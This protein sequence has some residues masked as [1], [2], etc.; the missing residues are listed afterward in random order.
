MS[1]Q[2][3]PT[4]SDALDLFLLDARA[5]SLA[6]NTITT[7]RFKLSPFV[8]WCESKEL[9][10][11]GEVTSVHL[12]QFIIA[13][14]QKD[15]SS[16][17][18]YNIA[19]TVKTFFN[20]CVTETLIDKSPFDRVK[21]PRLEKKIH[22]ALAQEEIKQILKACRNQRDRA[23]C[24]V[25]LDSGLRASELLALNGEDI[26]MQTGVVTVKLGKGGKDR[27]TLI[28][29][30]TRKILK[31]YYIE[32]GTPDPDEAVFLSFSTG[33][34][35][36]L[37]GIAQMMERLR[38]SSG[39]SECRCH[40]FR[41]TFALTCLRNGMNVYVLAK[42]MGHSDIAVL[43]QYLALIDDDLADAHR[44][45]GPADHLFSDPILQT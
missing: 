16:R 5:R 22:P 24:Y 9:T 4:I 20:F 35:L 31:R 12:R 38:R 30:S 34:R 21:L 39:V 41:R 28:G 33:E 2:R 19:K 11:L 18:R 36:T 29:A 32:R 13:L 26:D 45:F 27:V 8:D 1:D 15:I 25:L 6:K 43:K 10:V 23:I 37:F 7:Y 40:T 14:Q 44:A 42:L 17:T 3:A